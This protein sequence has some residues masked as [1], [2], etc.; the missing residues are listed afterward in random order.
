MA[1]AHFRMVICEFLNKDTDMV[2]EETPLI[3][4]DSNSSVCM[5]NNGNDIKYTRHISRRIIFVNN[6]EKCKMH[7]IG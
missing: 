4:L 7:K 2:S 5:V 3:I 6:G 1:L